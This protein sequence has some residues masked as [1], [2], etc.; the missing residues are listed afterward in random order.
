M[1]QLHQNRCIVES[2]KLCRS[3]QC[4]AYLHSNAHFRHLSL[5]TPPPGREGYSTLSSQIC[6]DWPDQGQAG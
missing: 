4:L 5:G 1:R 2:L 3:E 6:R